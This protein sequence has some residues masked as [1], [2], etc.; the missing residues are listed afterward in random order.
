MFLVKELLDNV[1][2]PSNTH[3]GVIERYQSNGLAYHNLD[4][5][6]NMWNIHK[7]MKKTTDN[8][9]VATAI[10]Y[11]DV[12]YQPRSKLNEILSQQLFLAHVDTKYREKEILTI[13]K[14]ILGTIDHWNIDFNDPDVDYFTDL[15]IAALGA[16]WETFERNAMNIRREYGYYIPSNSS[17]YASFSSSPNT[18]NLEVLNG[19]H[20]FL[21]NVL[22]QEHTFKTLP[23]RKRF[24]DRAVA[25]MRR[26]LQ[27][28]EEEKRSLLH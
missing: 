18:H 17:I 8:R 4:H 12:I 15:D 10:F 6:Q 1:M 27:S 22:R 2:T 24:E 3:G 16:D 26:M 21:S 7:E 19:T 25:N 23:F 20:K 11:H 9:L 13:S 28:I 14:M 5:L